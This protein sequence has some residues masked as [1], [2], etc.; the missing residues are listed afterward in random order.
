MEPLPKGAVVV[1]KSTVPVGTIEK[2]QKKFP[3]IKLLFNPEFLSEATCDEDFRHPDRQV[4]GYTAKSFGQAI[5]VLNTLPPSAYDVIVPSKEAELLKYMNNLRG[6]IEVME[7][8]HYWEVC[9]KEGLDYER[10]TKAAL[11]AKWVGAP[12][13]RHYRRI[14][15]NDFRGFGGKCFPKDINAWLEYCRKR[16]INSTLMGAVRKMNRRILMEQKLSEEQA[17]KK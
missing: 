10:V 13:G 7:S 15:H 2:L 14:F 8:N 6:M 17:E 4:V 9:E 11:A 16:G 3:R 5:K 12:M 1:L